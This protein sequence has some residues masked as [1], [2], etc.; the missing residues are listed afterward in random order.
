MKSIPYLL[1]ALSPLHAGT[2]Q[3]ADIIDLPIARMRSTG[4]P[5]VPGSS[6]KG[7]L[8]D[9]RQND[10][11]GDAQAKQKVE[12]V[13]GP[14]SKHASDHA[15]ALKVN[16]AR[17]L[18][19]PV[20]S[21]KGTFAFVT[22]PL[23]LLLAARDLEGAPAVPEVGPMDAAVGKKEGTVILHEVA[24]PPRAGQ[25][26]VGPVSR[27]QQA[28]AAQP[29]KESRLFLEDLDLKV[30][31][32]DKVEKWRSYLSGLLFKDTPKLFD[33][34]FAVVGDEVMSFLMETATQLDARIRLD[35]H[36]RT[37]ADGQLWTEESL[38]PETVLVGRLEADR[39]RKK[40]M[41][42]TE[43]QVLDAAL[44][45]EAVLQFGGKASVGRGRCRMI[46]VGG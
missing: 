32:S 5:I 40:E 18:L 17:L 39:S 21:F 13:F 42:M 11:K 30:S 44:P 9:A 2:G 46:Q 27:I 29:A 15:G 37:V 7:V 33:G 31:E 14:D 36:T 19:L 22:S 35:E 8:R 3:A 24:A 38:P 26:Q 34:R 12:A 45:T 4:I 20:R 1:H 10:A 43:E 28:P 41:S 6:V 16:D 23:L 25:A